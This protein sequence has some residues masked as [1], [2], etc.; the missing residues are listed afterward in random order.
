MA[1]GETYFKP[2]VFETDNG[3][4][5]VFNNA[6]VYSIGDGYALVNI[7]DLET[8]K[9]E[10]QV[11]LEESGEYDEYGNPIMIAKTVIVDVVRNYGYNSA[12][13]D[14]NLGE[15]YLL[16]DTEEE[17]RIMI[18]KQAGFAV[19]DNYIYFATYST[20]GF[21]N[22]GIVLHRIGKNNLENGKLENLTNQ[23]IFEPSKILNVSDN[24]LLL[25]GNGEKKYI[26][27]M[28]NKIPPT[29]IPT[30]RFDTGNGTYLELFGNTNQETF[31][32]YKD[33]VYVIDTN[34]NTLY[35]IRYGINN[36]TLKYKDHTTYKMET[37]GG[38]SLNR[39]DKIDE[40]EGNGASMVLG[41][42]NVSG[43]NI[44]IYIHIDNNGPN[45][46]FYYPDDIE[47]TYRCFQID[48]E[49]L[50]W[51][52]GI[53]GQTP[54]IHS[55]DFA[56]GAKTSYKV[57]GNYGFA[58]DEFSISDDGSFIF[59]QYLNSTDV[60]TFS[61]NPEKES[62]TSLL[63]TSKTDIHSIVNIKEI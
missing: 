34:G 10:P 36:G 20:N 37:W 38:P 39:L 26:I 25:N 4:K 5:V 12:I 53:G 47:D 18:F 30:I 14:F 50:Y 62:N 31:M 52:D 2:L 22:N 23:T 11:I 49:K 56:M 19:T 48:D 55:Y 54:Y 16:N 27:N 6:V 21:D 3:T 58:S 35:L 29:S 9:E 28:I 40:F 44:V 60:G 15:V 7:R 32:L 41:S 57:P 42:T 8:I 43:V 24:Y 45:V 17:D 1:P 13:M 33:N 59:W 61:W 46:K 51:I 63:S